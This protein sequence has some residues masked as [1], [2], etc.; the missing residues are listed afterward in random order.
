MKIVIISDLHGNLEAWNSFPEKEWDELWVLGDLVNYGPNPAEVIDALR[1]KA[2][3]IVRGNHDH[4]V[5]YEDDSKWSERYR[6]TAQ[7]TRRF[8]NASITADQK[9]YLQGLPLTVA[10]ERDGLRFQLVHARPSNPLYG[11]LSQDADEW[12]EEVGDL[13]ADVLL[14]GH[15]HQQFIRRIGRKILLNPGSIGQ[16]RGGGTAARYAVWDETGFELRSYEYPKDKTV[17]RLRAIGFDPS[18]EAEL[19]ATLEGRS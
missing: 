12:I 16:P 6:S 9:S 4:A 17:E 5:G 2:T 15:T 1:P 14:V 8:T 11:R 19:I 3:L 7:A 18:V 10:A 13:D